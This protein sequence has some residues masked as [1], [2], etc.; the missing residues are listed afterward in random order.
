MPVFLFI[1]IFSPSTR[2]LAHCGWHAERLHL[3]FMAVLWPRRLVAGLSLR[4]LWF[5]RTSVRVRFNVAPG[6][7]LLRVFRFTLV[8]IIPPMLHTHPHLHAALS[9]GGGDW[10]EKYFCLF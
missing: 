2:P 9:E 7:A 1:T 8:D 4:R 6:Q 3:S 10:M 5:D